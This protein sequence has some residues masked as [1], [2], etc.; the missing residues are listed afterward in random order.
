MNSNSEL[1]LSTDTD[2][3]S[4]VGEP[5]SSNHNPIW[6]ST[7]DALKDTPAPDRDR[8]L[9]V[10]KQ[11]LA[12][13]ASYAAECSRLRL[14]LRRCDEQINE[15]K[16]GPSSSGDEGNAS[17]EAKTKDAG[18]ASCELK[19]L[20]KQEI[21]SATTTITKAVADVIRMPLKK[22]LR[23]SVDGD[24]AIVRSTTSLAIGVSFDA[25]TEQTTDG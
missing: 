25:Q 1:E 16:L 11:L 21:L 6:D 19:P 12:D 13:N 8:V 22:S 17:N 4:L 5:D 15:L 9:Q 24:H 3:D 10:V 23:C 2:D 18:F 14:E 20:N 7:V